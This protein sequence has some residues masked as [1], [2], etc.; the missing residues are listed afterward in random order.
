MQTLEQKVYLVTGCAGFIG[1][2]LS[3]K[4]IANGHLVV[5]IDNLCNDQSNSFKKIRIEKL[6]AFGDEKFKFYPIDIIDKPALTGLFTKYS[7]SSII[8]LA[9]KTG[10]RESTTNYEEYFK[11]NTIGTC[12]VIDCNKIQKAPILFASSSSVYGDNNETPFSEDQRIEKPISLY[13]VSKISTELIAYN[14]AKNYNIP[15]IGLR[16]FTVY[17]PLGRPDMAMFLFIDAIYN[18]RTITLYNEGLMDRD[19]TFVDDIVDGIYAL[20]KFYFKQANITQL[21]EGQKPLI[22]NI[23]FGDTRKVRDL[24]TIIEKNLNIKAEINNIDKIKEDMLRTYSDNSKIYNHVGFK[25]KINLEEGVKR[26]VDW[27]LD[28]KTNS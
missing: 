25:A 8:H 24:V 27:Y 15:L 13:A 2:H 20:S 11:T 4:L 28:W 7:F 26:T 22:F 14:Y 23:G 12:N 10:V 6:L 19:F 17:G 9:A 5:G 1:H 3:E 18:K 21:I 16:F